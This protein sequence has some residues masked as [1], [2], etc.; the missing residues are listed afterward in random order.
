FINLQ[1]DQCQAELEAARQ[2]FGVQIHMAPGINLKDELDEAAALT[3]AL[4]LV[5]TAGTSVGDLAGALGKKTWRYTLDN[6]WIRLG[7]DHLPWS[8]S[9][10]LYQKKWNEPWEPLLQQ[11]GQDLEAWSGEERNT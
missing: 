11:I 6:V 7:T 9:V 5:I 10:A 2:Q 3:A 8:P 4:D 1:Y